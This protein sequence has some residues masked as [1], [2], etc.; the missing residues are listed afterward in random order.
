MSRELFEDEIVCVICG[1]HPIGDR[2]LTE[3]QYFTYPHVQL[4]LLTPWQS[5]VD[6]TLAKKTQQRR[7]TLRVPY[8]GAAVLAVSGTDLIATMPRRAAEM[9]AE[10]VRIVAFPFKIRRIRY[11]IAWHPTTNAEPA[12]VWF[13][14]QLA[15][16]FTELR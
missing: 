5:A 10:R 7:I 15:D 9:Y 3:K 1:K 14:E 8:Y 6:A 12:L 11:L 13:R 2:T 16:V 4:T